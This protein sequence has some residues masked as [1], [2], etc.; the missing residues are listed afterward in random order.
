MDIPLRGGDVGE[1]VPDLLVAVR[2]HRGAPDH[3]GDATAQSGEDVGEF[4]GDESAAH[5]HQ[6]LG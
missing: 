3:H 6:M 1:P 5:D 4:R 2:Q